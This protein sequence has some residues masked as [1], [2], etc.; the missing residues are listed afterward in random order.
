MAERVPEQA[1]SFVQD[2]LKKIIQARR[3]VQMS[4]TIFRPGGAGSYEATKVIFHMVPI[5]AFSG[6]TRL[7]IRATAP[8]LERSLKPLSVYA[9]DQN[10]NSRNVT[11]R[12][13]LDGWVAY[14]GGRGGQTSSYVQL[15]RN[16]TLEAVHAPEEDTGQR[17]TVH[18]DYEAKLSKALPDYVK[19]LAELEIEPPFLLCLSLANVNGWY[20]DGGAFKT[21]DF[22]FDTGIVTAPSVMVSEPGFDTDRALLELFNVIW[23]AGGVEKSPRDKGGKIEPI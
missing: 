7:D 10:L 18:T 1:I 8:Q 19:T 17:S 2:Q 15:F 16:G 3:P 23:Q 20:L 4:K 5:S 14:E 22:A 12:L 13:N 6:G 21:S 9:G 11:Y